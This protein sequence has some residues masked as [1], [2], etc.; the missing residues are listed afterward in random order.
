MP[1]MA[2][3]VPSGPVEDAAFEPVAQAILRLVVQGGDGL[4]PDLHGA[5]VTRRRDNGKGALLARLRTAA[6]DVQGRA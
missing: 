5:M 4:L 3:A 2:H 1:L 6:P